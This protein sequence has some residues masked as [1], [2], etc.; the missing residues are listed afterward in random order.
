MPA[1]VSLAAAL[2]VLGVAIYSIRANTTFMAIGFSATNLGAALAGIILLKQAL[3]T[4]SPTL[5]LIIGLLATV[6]IA[7]LAFKVGLITTGIGKFL[8]VALGM[9]ATY[10]IPI[11]QTVKA[12]H[13]RRNGPFKQGDRCATL[14]KGRSLTI[15]LDSPRKSGIC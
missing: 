9:L 11:N 4:I 15:T 13:C 3:D 2:V 14:A 10:L 8:V 7:L 5:G 1:S 6:G 12:A